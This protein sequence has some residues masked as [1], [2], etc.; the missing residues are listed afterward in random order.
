MGYIAEFAAIACQSRVPGEGTRASPKVKKMKE[1][2]TVA[3]SVQ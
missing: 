2:L 3:E 1:L